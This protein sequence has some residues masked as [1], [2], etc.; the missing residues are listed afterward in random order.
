MVWNAGETLSRNQAIEKIKDQAR[1]EGI[2]G[3]FKVYYNGAL[4]ANPEELPEQ[5]EME[6]VKVSAVLE[7]A[8]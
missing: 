1:D 4:I 6:K 5:V 3:A 7:N 8:I 2:T